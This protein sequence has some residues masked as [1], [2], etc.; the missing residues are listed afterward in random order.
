MKT[1]TIQ[2]RLK[3]V[4]DSVDAL[5]ADLITDDIVCISVFGDFVAL[6]VN[7]TGANKLNAKIGP[8]VEEQGRLTWV[9]PEIA[10]EPWMSDDTFRWASL[11]WPGRIELV[12]SKAPTPVAEPAETPAVIEDGFV[13]VD[14]TDIAT[15]DNPF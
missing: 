10:R 7:E 1:Q 15:D 14:S 6:Q 13:V 2:E 12:A 3:E 5:G 4:A 9:N 11:R 8:A